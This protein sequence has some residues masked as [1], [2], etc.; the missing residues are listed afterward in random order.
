VVLKKF[1][2]VAPRTRRVVARATTAIPTVASSELWGLLSAVGRWYKS[3]SKRGKKRNR[4]KPATPSRRPN[5][6]NLARLI[7]KSIFSV[8]RED[9]SVFAHET[10]SYDGKDEL[11]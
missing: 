7:T 9:D 1:I 2:M 4:I 6:S 8:V 5:F 11:N 3:I 10:Q